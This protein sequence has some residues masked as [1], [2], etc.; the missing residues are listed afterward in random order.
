MRRLIAVDFVEHEAD[1]IVRILTDVERQAA[2]L[3][4]TRIVGVAIDQLSERRDLVRVGAEL[5]DDHIGQ[6]VPPDYV[7]A[8]AIMVDPSLDDNG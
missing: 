3:E 5:D 6:R 8:P 7:V 2:V 1:G 4:R